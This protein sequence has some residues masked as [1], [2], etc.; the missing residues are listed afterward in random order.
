M[1]YLTLVCLVATLGGLLFGYD[2]AVIAGAL[3]FLKTHFELDSWM[4][5][6]TTS[7]ALI[8]CCIGVAVA[9]TMSDRF[10]R[11]RV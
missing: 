1:L 5:G 11:R 9:G 3:G 10:G 7:S 6:W 4:A 8:G 2:T